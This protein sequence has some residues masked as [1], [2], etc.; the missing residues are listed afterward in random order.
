MYNANEMFGVSIRT[1][2]KER[3]KLIDFV[4]DTSIK[5]VTEKIEEVIRESKTIVG[6]PDYITIIT[7]HTVDGETADEF[8]ITFKSRV[9]DTINGDNLK[10]STVIGCTNVMKTLLINF[11]AD[12]VD[13]YQ[14]T[15]KAQY[16]AKVLTD[17]VAP[18]CGDI[19]VAFT[20]SDLPIVS[21]T[22]NSVVL[23]LSAEVLA[24]LGT[25]NI[26]SKVEYVRGVARESLMATLQS[27]STPYEILTVKSGVLKAL[28]VTTRVG[29]AKLLRKAYR[30][31][32][33][34]MAEWIDSKVAKGEDIFESPVCKFEYSDEQGAFFGLMKCIKSDKVEDKSDVVLEK[35]GYSYVTVLSPFDKKLQTL[36]NEDTAV[37]LESVLA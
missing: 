14:L 1:E 11:I 18:M 27:L 30:K 12:W 31:N 35:G 22:N 10:A 7:A 28:D 34:G 26:F 23:G 4:G 17:V 21:M 19:K 24:S 5:G 20:Y 15:Y 2:L 8:K 33:K 3:T 9:K 25:F 13:N 29:V 16:N 6:V 37:L 32:I 36:S